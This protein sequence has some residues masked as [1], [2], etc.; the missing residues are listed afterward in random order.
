M[1]GRISVG[2]Y[3]VYFEA[4]PEEG[5]LDIWAE[6]SSRKRYINNLNFILSEVVEPVMGP[7]WEEVEEI[8]GGDCIIASREQILEM[9]KRLANLDGDI[10][11]ENALDEDFEEQVIIE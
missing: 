2:K 10:L 7:S 5:T 1:E 11:F 4:N 3:K 8:L 9:V 6:K